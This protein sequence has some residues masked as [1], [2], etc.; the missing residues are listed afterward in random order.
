MLCNAVIRD[1]M[2]IVV[3]TIML[4]NAMPAIPCYALCYDTG[5]ARHSTTCAIELVVVEK[6]T[7]SC[8][9]YYIPALSGRPVWP[10]R[11]EELAM[12]GGRDAPTL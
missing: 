9:K 2:F 10:S 3:R 4:R 7:V 12:A 8:S 6:Q 1:V 11:L 5:T